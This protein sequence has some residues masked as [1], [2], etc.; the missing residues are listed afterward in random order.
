MHT[1][2]LIIAQQII[3][4]ARVGLPPTQEASGRALA[5]IKAAQEDLRRSGR[6]ALDLDSARAAASVLALGHR[7]HKS[8]CIAAVQSIAAVLLREPQHVDEAQS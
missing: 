8:M 4:M 2:D 6:S 7:P 3:A 1:N 5:A